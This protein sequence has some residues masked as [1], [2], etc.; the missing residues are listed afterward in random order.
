MIALSSILSLF[1]LLSGPELSFTKNRICD[2]G[3]IVEGEVAEVQVGIRNIGNEELL[4]LSAI[5]T[6]NC[7][8]VVYPKEPIKSQQEERIII[9]VDTKG[10]FGQEKVV[11]KLLTNSPEKYA[12]IIVNIDVIDRKHNK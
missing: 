3:Q 10:K 8:S 11:V 2:V 7:T 6:C 4:I 1:V 5:T 9:R 12:I